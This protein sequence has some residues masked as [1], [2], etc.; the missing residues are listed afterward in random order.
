[1]RVIRFTLFFLA[2]VLR[3]LIQPK[4]LIRIKSYKTAI[5]EQCES[6][7]YVKSALKTPFF[8]L[9]MKIVGQW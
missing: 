4:T 7:N 3:M 8:C 1:M 5:F 6:L 9:K 2:S